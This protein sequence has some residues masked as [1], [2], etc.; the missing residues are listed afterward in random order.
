[1]H[2]NARRLF[3]ILLITVAM[4]LAVAADQTAAAA[5]GVTATAEAAAQAEATALRSLAAQSEQIAE[6]DTEAVVAFFASL[7]DDVKGELEAAG[8]TEERIVAFIGDAEGV[9]EELPAV[10]DLQGL[11]L[12]LAD[13][14]VPPLQAQME[15]LL[16][17]V[18][19]LPSLLT[20]PLVQEIGR[21]A[22]DELKAGARSPTGGEFLALI[23]FALIL[24]G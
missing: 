9:I 24:W 6:I 5:P 17:L 7:P 20:R 22:F 18:D 14:P 3:G 19:A 2:L 15:T 13:I 10:E 12:P 23:E 1:M 4:A 8:W 16:G 21:D 11:L